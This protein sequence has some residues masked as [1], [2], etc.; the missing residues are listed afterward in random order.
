MKQLEHVRRFLIRWNIAP[1]S[2]VALLAWSLIDGTHFYQ[3]AAC[4]L[5]DWH[6]GAIFTYLAAIAGII[7]KMYDSMQKDRGR[8]NDRD[9]EE[10]NQA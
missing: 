3:N 10:D 8:R 4:V 2:L 6:V 7:Y 5:P 1:L 9:S